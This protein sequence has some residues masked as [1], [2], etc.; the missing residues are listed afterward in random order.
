M[1]KAKT[2]TP[3]PVPAPVPVPVEPEPEPP[4]PQIQEPEPVPEVSVKSKFDRLIQARQELMS[5]LKAEIKELN[6]LSKDYEVALKAKNGKKK[7][8]RDFANLRRSTGFAE[9]VTVSPELYQFLTKTKA[10]IKDPNYKPT[11]EEEYNNW[12]RIPVKNGTPVARTDVT[13]HISKY[14]R[15]HNLQNPNEKREIVPDAVLTK[16]FSEPL[17]ISKSDANKKVYTY[18]KLQKYVNHHFTKK[19]GVKN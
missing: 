1:A 7:K 9:P 12:P 11:N 6:K 5:S 18:L 2:T 8:P 10:T 13:S 4:A 16:I 15:E 17:E 3:A 14:I 19:V